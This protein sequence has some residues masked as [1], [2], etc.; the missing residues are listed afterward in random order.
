MLN[1]HRLNCWICHKRITSNTFARS[2]FS[3]IKNESFGI[4]DDQIPSVQVWFQISVGLVTCFVGLFDLHFLAVA[5]AKMDFAGDDAPCAV[6]PSIDDSPR[7]ARAP[8]TRKTVMK[9]LRALGAVRTPARHRGQHGWTC[10]QLPRDRDRERRQRKKTEREKRRRMGRRQDKRREKIHFQCGGPFS[11]DGML[12]LV[13]SRCDPVFCLLSSV[14][15]DCSLILSVPLGRST[16]FFI[17]CE[18]IILCSYSF[19]F[20]NFSYAV[21]VS[22][23]P[24]YLIMQLQFFFCRN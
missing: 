20:Q 23:F 8:W 2:C 18:L 11:V 7:N 17:I 24:N 1:C 21:T 22:I 12:Y 16:V 19:F 10:P 9:A 14:K 5:C 3:L 6:C 13:N 4:E 15:Y